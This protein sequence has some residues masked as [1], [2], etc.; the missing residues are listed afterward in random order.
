[1]FARRKEEVAETPREVPIAVDVSVYSMNK[2]ANRLRALE[3]E[4]EGAF[5]EWAAAQA[6]LADDSLIAEFKMSAPLQAAWASWRAKKYEVQGGAN[7]DDTIVID[8]PVGWP[9]E[10]S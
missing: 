7:G 5:E 8:T 6:A 10:A 9:S 4:M 3:T 1:M 2:G